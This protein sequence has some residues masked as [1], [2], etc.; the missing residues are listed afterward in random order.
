MSEVLDVTS[1]LLP[2]FARLVVTSAE[3]RKDEPLRTI[4][5][6]AHRHPAAGLAAPRFARGQFCEGGRH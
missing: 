1:G 4:V 6:G 5:F 3:T 2:S